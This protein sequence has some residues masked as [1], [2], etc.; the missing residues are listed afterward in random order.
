VSHPAPYTYKP[1]QARP[2][3]HLPPVVDHTQAVSPVSAGAMSS[4][5]TSQSSISSGPTWAPPCKETIACICENLC[6]HQK[7]GLHDKNHEEYLVRLAEPLFKV[8]KTV[9]FKLNLITCAD[10][11]WGTAPRAREV[12]RGSVHNP[13]CKH[14]TCSSNQIRRHNQT[15]IC[16][17]NP[18]PFSEKIPPIKHASNL[19]RKRPRLLQPL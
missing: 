18:S 11:V 1:R 8:S 6:A 10:V 4:L 15:Q 5:A 13:S 12:A 9:R 19:T 17:V 16:K 7:N 14:S 3:G 2:R